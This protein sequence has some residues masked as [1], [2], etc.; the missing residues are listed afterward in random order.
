MEG[1]LAQSSQYPA[2]F[3]SADSASV[4]SQ[5]WYLLLSSCRLWALVAVAA[6]AAFAAF[7]D[8]WTAIIAL[9]PISIAVFVEVLLLAW[10]PDRRWY[11]ARAVAESAKTLAWRYQVGGWPL[12]LRMTDDEAS[13]ELIARLRSLL[14]R[15]QE[16]SLP[17]TQQ[18]Q[19]TAGMRKLRS[20]PL[21]DRMAEYQRNRIQDQLAWYAS[22]ADWNRKRA[23]LF[24]VGL[25]IIE[26]AAFAA[27]ILTASYGFSVS[28]YSILAALAVAGVGWLQIRQH[29]SMAD[30]YSLASHDLAAINSTID[31]VVGEDT[32]EKFVDQAEEAISREHTLWLT[33]N[34][35][36]SLHA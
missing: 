32:W 17:P 35:Q 8:P 34:S 33:S 7:V 12:G 25:I 1:A 9:V 14:G 30:A 24:Q 10:R 11:Q 2:I 36:R 20:L 3:H 23:T 4:S 6:L 5:R 19:I 13:A 27:A 26:L 15:F 31:S 21:K 18:D 28:V 22:K 16:L 29:R